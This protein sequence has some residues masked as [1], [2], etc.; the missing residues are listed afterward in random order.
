MSDN[1]QVCVLVNFIMQ[2]LS[3]DM[4]CYL[5]SFLSF[6]D[7]LSLMRTSKKLARIYTSENFWTIK[8]KSEFGTRVSSEIA[9]LRCMNKH[10]LSQIDAP[11]PPSHSEWLFGFNYP[12]PPYS[13]DKKNDRFEPDLLVLHANRRTLGFIFSDVPGSQ[14]IDAITVCYKPRMTIEGGIP[15]PYLDLP[16]LVIS[17]LLREVVIPYWIPNSAFIQIFDVSMK[18]IIF[19]RIA[20]LGYANIT[21]RVKKE[22]IIRYRQLW[23]LCEN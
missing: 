10:Y 21:T 20:A 2:S 9:K 5:G 14:T 13:M 3:N 8:A 15:Y 7:L 18:E 1:I 23:N 19:Q 11:K 22:D 12:L 6:H 16:Q 17:D 4:L